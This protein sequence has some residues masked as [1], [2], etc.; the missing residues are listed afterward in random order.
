[1]PTVQFCW[2]PFH[3]VLIVKVETESSRTIHTMV[4]AEVKTEESIIS[5]FSAEWP[6]HT[7]GKGPSS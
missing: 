5:G 1:M 6:P 7:K 3:S 4:S 2:Q